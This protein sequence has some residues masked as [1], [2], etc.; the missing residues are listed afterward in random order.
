M[1]QDEARFGRLSEPRACWA[2][3]ELRPIIKSAL[4]REY[5]YVFGA[6]APKTG[7][8]DFMI[9]DNMKTENM[10][11]FLRQVSQ[12]HRNNFIIM[13]VDGA[14]THRSK[15]LVVPKNMSLIL[16]PPY[17]PE[18]NPTEMV[19]NILRRDCLANKYFKTL[20]DPINGVECGL[21]ELLDNKKKIRTLTK[22]PWINK[23]LNTT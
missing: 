13:V 16:L 12:A 9:A 18:L 7:S 19:W 15:E 17:S 8:C 3:Q 14:S 10:S 2:H 4:I 22:W 20:A 11:L 1:F 21:N 6:V 5:N 23:I